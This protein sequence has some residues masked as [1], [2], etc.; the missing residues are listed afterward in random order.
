MPIEIKLRFDRGVESKTAEWEE[1]GDGYLHANA[2]LQIISDSGS[3]SGA[4]LCHIEAV[5]VKIDEHGIQAPDGEDAGDYEHLANIA[6]D[7]LETCKIPGWPGEWVIWAQP[8][9]R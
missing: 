3:L 6:G 9:A 1:V 7:A 2:S 4:A 5:R 8:F